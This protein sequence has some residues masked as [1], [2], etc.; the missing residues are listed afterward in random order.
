MYRLRSYDKC[1][2]LCRHHLNEDKGH[3]YPLGRFRCVPLQ[4]DILLY[5]L[6]AT[7][8]LISITIGLFLL[9][10]LCFLLSLGITSVKLINLLNQWFVAF[11]WLSSIALHDCAPICAHSSNDKHLGCF[12]FRTIMNKA[13]AKLCL[14]V[15]GW[16]YVL[17]SLRVNT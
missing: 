13:A 4:S 11:L 2:N 16:T 17:I 1:T 6:Q 5:L 3:L 8:N 12:Q 9:F 15:L 14:Q 10:L 7:N